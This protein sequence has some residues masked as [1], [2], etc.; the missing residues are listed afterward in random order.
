MTVSV[1]DSMSPWL[2]LVF[3]LKKQGASLRVTVWRKLQRFGA[4][5]LG[6]SGYLIPNTLENRERFE[7]LATTIRSGQGEASIV[8]VK[9]IDNY[10]AP[11]LQ[12]RFTEARG[13]DYQALLRDVRKMPANSSR[14]ARATRMRQRFQEIAS[15]D[16]F[17]SPIRKKVE[18]AVNALEKP[19]ISQENSD[20]GKISPAAYRNRVWVTR[21]RPGVD[22][23]TSAWLIRKLIDPKARFVFASE[24]KKPANAVPYDMYEG[25]FGHRGEDCT[26]ETLL[27]AFRIR[28]SRARVMG[29]IVHDADL[30]DDKFGRKEGFG[31]DEVMKGWARQGLSDKELLERGAL[32]AEGLY[33]S[34]R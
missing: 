22:R 28:D 2:L 24:G 34:L 21:P 3:S 8:E 5:P 15:I 26:F 9:S 13:R 18:D 33:D 6:N 7:W 27:K 4:V 30:L 12:Q 25:G 1:S 20:M 32:L 17:G 31:I 29:Q 16:F 23:V 19:K 10:S 11:R 14:S